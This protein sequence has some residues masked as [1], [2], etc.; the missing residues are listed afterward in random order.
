MAGVK[1]MGR[2]TIWML[3]TN[4]KYELPIYT[5]DTAD[6]LGYYMGVSGDT[7]RTEYKRCCEGRCRRDGKIIKVNIG[8][9]S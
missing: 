4:D 8:G 9:L 5:G 7:V 1:G 2:D 3:V 6:E